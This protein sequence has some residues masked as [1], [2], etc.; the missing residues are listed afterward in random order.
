MPRP[1]H[2]YRLPAGISDSTITEKATTP[3]QVAVLLLMALRRKEGIEGASQEE[4][5][6]LVQMSPRSTGTAVRALEKA[7]ALVKNTP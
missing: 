6:Q 2:I 4:I 3:G 5:T 1:T 7:G